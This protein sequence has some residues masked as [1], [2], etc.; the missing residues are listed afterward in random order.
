MGTQRGQTPALVAARGGGDRSQLPPSGAGITA[1]QPGCT[2]LGRGLEGP[3][4]GCIKEIFIS[5][6]PDEDP[7]RQR[8]LPSRHKSQ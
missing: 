1:T 5:W 4:D 3:L 2:R 6:L 8:F 7:F